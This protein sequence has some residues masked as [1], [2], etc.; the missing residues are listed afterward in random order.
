M[1]FTP[2]GRQILTGGSPGTFSLD[3]NQKSSVTCKRSFSLVLGEHCIHCLFPAT[4]GQ[5][6]GG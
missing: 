1:R 2:E 5:L 4:L 6:R 3:R